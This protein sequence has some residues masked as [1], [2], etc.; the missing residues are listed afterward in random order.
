MRL[1][2]QKK[3]LATALVPLTILGLV[4][5]ALVTVSMQKNTIRQV[6]QSLK[7][8]A[9]ATLSAYD[10]NSGDYLEADNGAIW[11]GNYNISNSDKLLDTIKE[12]SGMEVT[13]IYG[14]RRI[15]TS[16]VDENG[17]RI[18]GSPV[19]DKVKEEVLDKGHSYFS[20]NVSMNGVI[21]YGY[22]EPVFQDGDNTTPI[23]MVFAG[24]DKHAALSSAMRTIWTL[25]AIM[26]V[27]LVICS[28]VI[29][30]FSYS[31]TS[32]IKKGILSIQELS[33]GNL[34]TPIDR[35]CLNRT[36][37]IGDMTKA[38]ATLESELKKII[39]GIQ[40]STNMLL[41]KSNSLNR[42]SDETKQN[43]S[44]VQNTIS[45]IIVGANS[46]AEDTNTASHNIEMMDDLIVETSQEA[47]NLNDRADSMLTSSDQANTTIEELKKINRKVQEVVSGIE[48]LTAE[49]SESAQKIGEASR[50]ISEIAEQTNLLSLNASIEA[51]RAGEAGR[52]FAVVASEIQ[53]LA[54]QSN[55]ASSTIDEIVSGLVTNFEKVTDSMTEM[56]SVVDVQNHNIDE[57]EQTVSNVMSQLH[58]SVDSIRRIQNQTRELEVSRIAMVDAIHSLAQIANNNVESTSETN[59]E[60]AE[61][62]QNFE[63]VIETASTLQKT[64]DMLSQNISNFQM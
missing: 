64:A 36:D 47:K 15:M 10:Q 54:Q 12:R 63:L 48:R 44:N 30:R 32:A 43:I 14:T 25:I 29:L 18:L 2:L 55:V 1:S 3:L 60:I 17:D 50:L 42:T 62:S 8:T 49:T 16:A 53:N 61:V 5:I 38:V 24:V 41:E 22:Y 33:R 39:G 28:L 20:E 46:Q 52:G 11:K 35:Q 57:T 7:G 45:E 51:A 13:F 40:N 6:E 4:I 23:G 59:S 37:E 56:L 58:E 19:G 34:N 31:I 9:V 21:C 27:I 26:I